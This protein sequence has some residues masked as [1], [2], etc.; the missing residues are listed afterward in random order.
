MTEK[1]TLYERKMKRELIKHPLGLIYMGHSRVEKRPVLEHKMLDTRGSMGHV[2]TFG[3]K[4]LTIYVGHEN[5]VFGRV[6]V[7]NFIYDVKYLRGKGWVATRGRRVPVEQLMSDEAKT[8]PAWLKHK[9]AD[10]G[11]RPW[12]NDPE[13]YPWEKAIIDGKV[14]YR[15]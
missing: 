1:L 14:K 11:I 12:E 8:W 10:V 13:K 4:P 15:S 2:P 7:K 5:T 3:G 6:I 9:R